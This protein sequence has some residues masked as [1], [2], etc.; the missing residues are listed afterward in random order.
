MCLWMCI[1]KSVGEPEITTKV[2]KKCD[3]LI[4]SSTKYLTGVYK[5]ANYFCPLFPRNDMSAKA[6][7]GT[8]VMFLQNDAGYAKWGPT[9][10][11]IKEL[12]FAA[13]PKDVI[14]EQSSPS[15]FDIPYWIYI[16]LLYFVLMKW[17]AQIPWWNAVIGLRCWHCQILIKKK[18]KKK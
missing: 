5:F 9:S 6:V 13:K 3:K 15:W 11:K 16:F 18:R 7:F 2:V 14:K 1:Q 12:I 17:L 10:E 8:L 4:Q